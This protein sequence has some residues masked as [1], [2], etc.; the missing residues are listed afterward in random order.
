MF[1][2]EKY[3]EE[4]ELKKYDDIIYKPELKKKL[5]I[6]SIDSPVIPWALPSEET[7]G[8]RFIWITLRDEENHKYPYWVGDYTEPTIL[9]RLE[10]FLINPEGL[11]GMYFSAYIINI[12]AKYPFREEFYDKILG[13]KVLNKTIKDTYTL[14]LLSDYNFRNRLSFCAKYLKWIM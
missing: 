5:D 8:H 1:F 10:K 11:E 13:K 9:K 4:K 6:I 7:K 12:K 3:F 2:C 14:I